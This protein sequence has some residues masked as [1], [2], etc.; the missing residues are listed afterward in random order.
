MKSNIVVP[1]GLHFHNQGEPPNHACTRGEPIHTHSAWP[2]IR[3]HIKGERP[4]VLSYH[5]SIDENSLEMY[6]N[7]NG[8]LETTAGNKHQ[9]FYTFTP[10]NTCSLWQL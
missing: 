1:Q 5:I 8:K 10:C 3:T 6:G 2:P 4:V 7:K 9:F